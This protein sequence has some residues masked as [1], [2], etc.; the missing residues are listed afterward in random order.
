MKAIVCTKYGSLD[1]LG[2]KDVPKPKP[3][4]NEVLI[5]VHAASMNASDIEILRCAWSFRLVGPFR[6]RFKI[7]GSDV[8]G[9]VDSFGDN[10]RRFKP[11][12]RVFGDLFMAGFGAFAEY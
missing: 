6:P 10:V 3:K 11:G 4:D 8:A 2:L 7:P 5:K 9:V 1:V 12:D